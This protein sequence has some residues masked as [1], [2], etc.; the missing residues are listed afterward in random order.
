V[1]FPNI[2]G[3]YD[4]RELPLLTLQN[5][6]GGEAAIA[7]DIRQWADFHNR[8]AQL[9]VDLFCETGT[10]VGGTFGG[11]AGGGE[12]QPY[13]EYGET[14]ATRT[15][16][17]K[18]SWGLPI[19]RYRDRQMYTEEYLAMA[20]LERI[21]RD[22]ISATN[23]DLTTRVKMVIRALV[24]NV[25]YTFNDGVF[26]GGERGPLFVKRLFN[27]DATPGNAFINGT[28]LALGTLQSYLP[29]GAGAIA[30]AQFTLARTKLR[31][32]GY[33]AKVIHVISDTDADTV[34]GMAGFIPSLTREG[35][36]LNQYVNVQNGPA[37][38]TTTAVVSRPQSIGVFNDGGNSDGEVVVVP[39]W[40]AGYT[41]SFDPTKAKTLRIREHENAA[42]RGFNLVQDQ[43]RTSYGDGALRNKRWE[44]IAG[45][46]V[47]N[48]LN[49]V[50][51]KATAGAYTVPAV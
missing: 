5:V 11:G 32:R 21:N 13:A 43:S 34:R 50:L 25:N 10:E 38:T 22:T 2:F 6:P 41:F 42:Y 28:P 7:E 3:A 36:Q 37:V 33:T 9:Y 30:V 4:T 26:P 35:N 27:N 51:I 47:V 1:F 45:A 23:R 48:R 46:G 29:S 19:R 17:T 44:R 12:L 8:V 14:E 18:W 20:T 40:P 39:F 15:D 49:G 24:G 31:E 16:E